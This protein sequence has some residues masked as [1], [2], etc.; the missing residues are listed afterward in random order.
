[1]ATSSVPTLL[2]LPRLSGPRKPSPILKRTC[3]PVFNFTI[4]FPVRLVFPSVRTKKKWR[5][6]L[7]QE[8]ESK[9][10]LLIEVW[11]DD[12]TSSDYLGGFSLDLAAI[13]MTK[14]R[15]HRALTGPIKKEAVDED[16]EITPPKSSQWFEVEEHT[17]VYDGAKTELKVGATKGRRVGTRDGG[18]AIVGRWAVGM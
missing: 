12:D 4:F 13:F 8:L 17:R 3:R 14:N 16:D 11:D 10:A 15:Q 7:R 6:A 9:G 5:T 18:I 2:V 1:M